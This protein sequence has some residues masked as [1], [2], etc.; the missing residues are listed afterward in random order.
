MLISLLTL[1]IF[2]YQT[3]LQKE[4]SRLSVR[5]RLGFVMNIT[6]NKQDSTKHTTFQLNLSVRNNGLGPA[7]IE[8]NHIVDKGKQYKVLNFF[9]KAYPKLSEY[10]VFTQITELEIG[11]AIP[12]STT[13]H[14]FD[15]EFDAENEDKIKEY[16]N[17]SKLYEMPFDIFIEYSSMYEE[18]WVVQSNSKGHPKKIN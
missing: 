13:V 2:F 11:Q 14:I 3:N 5:P 18:K 16:L 10:G 17:I 15:Y 12:A 4:Q 6:V 7:I 8:A 1:F 9:N